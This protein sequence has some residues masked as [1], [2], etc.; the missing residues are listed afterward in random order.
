MAYEK[1][2]SLDQLLVHYGTNRP[3]IAW[4]LGAGASRSSGMP[5]AT[6][7]IWDL[8]RKFYCLKQNQEISSNE[9]SSDI[10]KNKIQNYLKG[11][12]APEIWSEGEYAYYFELVF[13]NDLSSQQRYLE[14]KLASDKISIT[15]GHRVLSALMYLEQAKIVFTTNFDS[16]LENAYAQ[17]IG[18]D[19]HA[20]S[21]D[22][23]YGA[24]DAL[25]NE[26]FPIYCKMHGDFRYQAMKNLPQDLLENDRKIE[27]TFLS[28]ATRYGMIVSGYSGRDENVMKAFDEAIE[29]QNAFSKGLFWTI[30]IGGQ[31]LPSVKSLIEK[32]RKTGIMAHIVEV[33]T[34]DSLMNR[35]WK[36]LDSKP[37]DI[38]SKIKREMRTKVSIGRS[39]SGGQFP[40]V[41][42]NAFPI[43]SFPDRCLSIET[44][45]PITAAVLKERCSE[46]NSAALF[47]RDKELLAWGPKEE[48]YKVIPKQEIK[49]E[50]PYLFDDLQKS[51]TESTLISSFVYHALARALSKDG[52]LK[53]RRKYNRFFLAVSS[54][55]KKD[56]NEAKMLKTALS[57]YNY[58][59]RR[60]VPAS[61]I[62]G[63]VPRLPKTFWMEAVEVSLDICEGKLCL[64]LNQDL[65]IEPRDNRKLAKEFVKKKKLKR[66]NQSQNSIID[67]WKL[68][69]FQG[70][71]SL[72]VSP[73]EIDDE[74][75]N[76]SFEISATTAYSQRV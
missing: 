41:R 73:F 69:L 71:Q 74:V 13:G 49:A 24:L 7:I 17:T 31:I 58:A 4:L 10:V 44:Y 46:I 60:M 32:A 55:I 56:D 28:A 63:K 30:P 39:N 36:Q 53:L 66:Y 1:E 45:E 18:N 20:F 42:T 2:F 6:D 19:L 62:S 15:T 23:S 65:W 27:Q 64:T 51:F 52:R 12:G 50:K 34:F 48:I 11:I 35:I 3:Q 21:L 25:N 37:E 61:G 29:Q 14:D 5:T 33:E 38:H 72:K 22:G 67:A 47:V 40:A 76:P 26:N 54:N 9:L 16:V 75:L 70:N 8:K 68:I 43:L 59:Q 57:T